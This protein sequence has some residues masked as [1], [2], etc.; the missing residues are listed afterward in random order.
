MAEVKA[1]RGVFAVAIATTD[2]LDFLLE[3]SIYWKT[4]RICAWIMRFI[5]NLRSRKTGR[6]KGPLTTKETNKARIFW[7]KRVQ[8]RAT[9]DKHYQEDRLQPNLQPNKDGILECLGRNQGHF[10]VYLPDRQCFTEKLVT[11]MGSPQYQR[12]RAV[13]GPMP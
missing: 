3:K 1:T 6:L 10:S 4:M 2:K 9:A 7:V 12:W 13:L 5:H 11:Q 8:T